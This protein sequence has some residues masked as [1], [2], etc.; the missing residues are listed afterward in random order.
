MSSLQYQTLKDVRASVRSTT[1]HTLSRKRLPSEVEI[2]I[3]SELDDNNNKYAHVAFKNYGMPEVDF[4]SMIEK[5]RTSLIGQYNT[6]EL[7]ALSPGARKAVYLIPQDSTVQ[8]T[9]QGEEYPV[10]SKDTPLPSIRRMRMR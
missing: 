4:T 10:I 7:L 9:I 3:A 1:L 5:V 6:S 2:F 8:L